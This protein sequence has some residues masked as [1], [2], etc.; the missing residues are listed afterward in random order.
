MEY[1]IAPAQRFQSTKTADG[2]VIPVAG[3]VT[4]SVSIGNSEYL[5]NVVIVPN[6]SYKVVLGRDF[7]HKFNALIDVRGHRV[8]FFQENPVFFAVGDTPPVCSD[9]RV[10]KT[11]VIEGIVKS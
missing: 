6:L 1:S 7:L 4:F 2:N 9:V 5:C 11:F 3:S 8:T 10:A